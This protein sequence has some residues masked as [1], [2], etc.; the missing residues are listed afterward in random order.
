MSTL[1]QNRED[2]ERA[3]VF[4]VC[5]RKRTS[6]L[7]VNEYGRSSACGV[8]LRC[9]LIP[10]RPRGFYQTSFLADFSACL[11]PSRVMQLACMGCPLCLFVAFLSNITPSIL[12]T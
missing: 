6:D 5:F 9:V 10:N 8:A 4:P 1:G 3:H 2:S 12:K 7:R 11:W